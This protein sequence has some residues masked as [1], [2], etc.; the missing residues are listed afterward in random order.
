MTSAEWNAIVSQLRSDVDPDGAVDAATRLHKGATG[1][2][3]PRLLELLQDESF[4]VREAAA[5]PL[6]EL[7]GPDHLLELLRAFQRGLDEGHD[8]DGFTAALID[9]AESEPGRVGRLLKALT[10]SDDESTRENAEWL[11]TFCAPKQDA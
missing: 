2:D 6:T 11:L 8:N 4:F 3:V 7:A 9:L 10:S 1:E 5:W